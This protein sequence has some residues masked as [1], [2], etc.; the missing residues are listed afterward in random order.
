MLTL[1]LTKDLLK[2][3]KT[4]PVEDINV[5]PFLSWHVNI[6]ILNKRKHIVFVN[7]LARLAIIIDGIRTGQLERLKDKFM[8]TFREYLLREGVNDTLINRYL[9]YCTEVVISKTN[10]RSVLGTMKE[11]TWF[12]EDDF[13]DNFERLKWLNRMIHKPIDYM[14]PINYFKESLWDHKNYNVV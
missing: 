12:T 11:V 7:D 5:A 14:E 3:M 13:C 9:E 4:T 8:L 1:R 10:N 2:D 6:Y